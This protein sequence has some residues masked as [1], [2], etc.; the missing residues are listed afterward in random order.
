[1]RSF[2]SECVANVSAY[3]VRPQDFTRDRKLDFLSICEFMLPLLKKGLQTELN[4]FFE[5]T[6]KT[7]TKSAFCQAREKIKPEFFKDMYKHSVD[8][9]YKFQLEKGKNRFKG[10]RLWA[11]DSSVQVLPDNESTRKLGLGTGKSKDTEIASVK[12]GAYYDIKAQIIGL[13]DIFD[14]K[15]SDLFCCAESQISQVPAD[16]ISI[17]DRGYCSQLVGYLHNYYGTKY[18]CRMKI[19]SSTTVNNFFNSAETDILVTEKLTVK[20]AKKLKEMGFEV[21]K[22]TTVSYRL[23]K[24]TLPTGEI[25]ILQTNLGADFSIA[26]LSYIYKCRWGVE[27]CFKGLKSNQMLAI[28]SGYSDIAVT[29]DLWIN[30]LFYNLETITLCAT[31]R[32]LEKINQKRKNN[33]SKNKKKENKGYQVNR[34]IGVGT[35]RMEYRELFTCKD[36]QLD[37]H[38]KK[39][40]QLYLMSLEAKYEKKVQPVVDKLKKR[41]RHYTES[42]Y[43]RAI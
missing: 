19:T 18:V 31:E 34:N 33:P 32:E 26:D 8:A 12:I 30:L 11:C 20:C 13:V 35:L 25:E 9:F 2:L 15:K 39:I 29:Q 40:A 6:G 14:A 22:E 41:K 27:T 42:N 17:Y 36:S 23:V 10:Y 7:C 21:T 43:K 5:D 4:L 16:V 38:I 24:V 3:K 28:F 37:A 1:M